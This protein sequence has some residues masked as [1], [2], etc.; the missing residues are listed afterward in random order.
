MVT[1]YPWGDL[2]YVL[3]HFSLSEL[4]REAH[5]AEVNLRVA[6]SFGYQA[7]AGEWRSL[8]D[9]FQEAVDELVDGRASQ[10]PRTASGNPPGIRAED[11]KARTDIVDYIGRYVQLKKRGT[12]FVGLCPFHNEKTPSFTV[13]PRRQTWHC[14]GACG[15]GGD[16]IAF[17]MRYHHCDF[18]AVLNEL[19]GVTI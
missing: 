19:S 7:E 8:T 16:V 1:L 10:L 17:A 5:A 2:L 6:S 4:R 9:L 3:A 15:T 14:F 18:K 12:I 11:V 13:S